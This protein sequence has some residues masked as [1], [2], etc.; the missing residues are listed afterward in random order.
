[1]SGQPYIDG[2]TLNEARE[3]LRQGRTLE[4]LAGILRCSPEHLARLLGIPDV[5][6]ATSNDAE[7]GFDLWAVDRLADV[8]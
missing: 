3:A 4:A 7:T 6:P 5:K 1:M 8:L 2:S